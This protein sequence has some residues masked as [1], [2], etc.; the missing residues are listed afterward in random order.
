M[1]ALAVL[2]PFPSLVNALLVA[3]LFR[4]AGGDGPG[5]VGLSAA[6]FGLQISI[7]TLN[8]LVDASADAVV[9]P[10]KPIPS[11]LIRPTTV[12]A[13]CV[14]GGLLGVVTY[15]AF[16][17][18]LFLAGLAMLGCGVAYD[19]WLKRAGWGWVA[20]AVAF[21]L[22]PVSTWL[23]AT[24]GLPP[25]PEFL[26]PMAALAGPALQLSNGLVDL[27]R[28]RLSGIPAPAVRLGRTGSLVMLAALLAAVYMAAWLSLGA[29]NS[30]FAVLAAVVVATLLAVAGMGLSASADPRR[31]ERGW[32]AQAIGLAVLACGWLASIS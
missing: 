21:P 15:A 27:E 26:L 19:V 6:M 14:G 24:G 11:G 18:A 28:D 22:L 2:H 29:S 3:A 7:G 9:K 20:F 8:D 12:R 5:A 23:A 10:W 13:I 31:R 25:R 4:L 1:R 32:E 17:P 30:G 16:G